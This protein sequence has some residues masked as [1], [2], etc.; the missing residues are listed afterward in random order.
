MRI[1]DLIAEVIGDLRKRWLRTGLTMTGIIA[2]TLLITSMVAI[3]QGLKSFLEALWEALSNP[4]LI[5]IF[6]GKINFRALMEDAFLQ[7]GAPPREVKEDSE[8]DAMRRLMAAGPRFLPYEKVAEVK[9]IPGVVDVWPAVWLNSRW[10]QIEGDDRKW[11]VNATPWGWAHTEFIPLEAGRHFSGE[12]VD[13]VILSHQ[14]LD[15]LGLSDSEDLIGRRVRL[16]IDRSYIPGVGDGFPLLDPEA[17]LRGEPGV[18]F[19]ATVVGLMKRTLFSTAALIPHGRARQLGREVQGDETLFTEEKYSLAANVLIEREEQLPE[20]MA[21]IAKLDIGTRSNAQRL[22]LFKSIFFFINF[23][24]SLVGGAALVVAALGIAN[25]LLMSVYERTREIGLYMAL[26]ATRRTIRWLYAWE[27]AAIGLLG[28]ALGVG[29]AVGLGELA[30]MIFHAVFE[31]RWEGYSLFTFPT[32][33]LA[34]TVGFAVLVAAV[35]GI[36]PS[37]RAARLDPMQALRYD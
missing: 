16:Q 27:A 36:Y 21:A 5:T 2:G 13:E 6:P 26:G 17:A 9:E 24:L 11:T 34:G 28:G 35:A 37:H 3:G 1:T 15:S 18:L 8:I 12:S 20:V 14:Y 19:E 10:I 23:A 7:I 31:T 32:W 30:N 29:L 33:L 4:R 25:T 22:E